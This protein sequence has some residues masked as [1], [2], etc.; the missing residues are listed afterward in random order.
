MN[1]IEQRDWVIRFDALLERQ[2]KNLAKE[3]LKD[4]DEE[5]IKDY[6]GEYTVF[7]LIKDSL[8]DED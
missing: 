2:I 3:L 4:V 8:K 5:I 7:E 6:Y 1:E